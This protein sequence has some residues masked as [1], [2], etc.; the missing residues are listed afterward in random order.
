MAKQKVESSENKYY[1]MAKD[2]SGYYN[3]MCRNCN[4][5][6]IKTV[7]K[8]DGTPRINTD[9]SHKYSMKCDQNV[10]LCILEGG[11]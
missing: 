6:V 9:K 1:G 8:V 2:Q 5:S 7:N 3:D 10:A 4:R 11:R